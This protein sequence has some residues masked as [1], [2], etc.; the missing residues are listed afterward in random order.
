[1][2][3]P[4]EDPDLPAETGLSAPLPDEQLIAPGGRATPPK[5]VAMVKGRIARFATATAQRAHPPTS[6]SHSFRP[7]V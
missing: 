5:L 6:L 2:F 7:P 1:M 3:P 4:L